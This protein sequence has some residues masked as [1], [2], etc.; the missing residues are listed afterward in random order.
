MLPRI[1]MIVIVVLI[2]A[3][4]IF[5]FT[6][7]GSYQNSLQARVEYFLGNYKKSLTLAKKAYEQDK[8]NKMAFAMITQSQISL[9][10]KNYL[11]QGEQYLNSINAISQKTNVTKSD[12]SKIKIM[13]EVMVEEFK[14]LTPTKMTN[15]SLIENSKNMSQKFQQIHDGLF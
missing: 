10:Y 9:K 4:G 7:S 1:S 13:C 12:K 3:F 8:Y 6:N 14:N 2:L 5:F 15:D 11:T